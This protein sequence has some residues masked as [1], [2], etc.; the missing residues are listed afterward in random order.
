M[1]DGRARYRLYVSIDI[2]AE[3]FTAAW[4][5]PGGKPTAPLTGQQTV[6]GCATLARCLR[7]TTI[8]LAATLAVLEFARPTLGWPWSPG[9]C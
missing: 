6:A 9:R 1:E 5:A 7:T 3:T 2:A 8:P 4:L